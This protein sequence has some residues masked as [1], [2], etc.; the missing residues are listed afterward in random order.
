MSIKNIYICNAAIVFLIL[1]S[2]Q[3]SI[4]NDSINNHLRGLSQK[5]KW[6]SINEYLVSF[7]IIPDSLSSMI[8]ELVR[9]SKE[10]D[11]HLLIGRSYIIKGVTY[12]QNN[13][14]PAH[15]SLCSLQ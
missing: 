5:E 15:I 7:D 14:F 1:V 9:I 10:L 11:D 3:I 8:N 12:S 6:E 2:C 4:A 13:D